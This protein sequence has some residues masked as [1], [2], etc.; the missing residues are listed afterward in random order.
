MNK[1]RQENIF[2]LIMNN[3]KVNNEQSEGA[4]RKINREMNEL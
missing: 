3:V 2:K 1:E 4:E